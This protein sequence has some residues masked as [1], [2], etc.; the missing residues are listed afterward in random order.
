MYDY[1]IVTHIANFYK[2]NLYN[3]LAKKLK[4][5]VVFTAS[6]TNEKRAN[7]FIALANSHFEYR[8]LYEGDYEDRDV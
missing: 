7:D 3:Q 1:L 4:I 6:N 2:V 5:L 8:L